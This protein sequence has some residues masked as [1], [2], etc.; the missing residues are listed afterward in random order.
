MGSIHKSP[1]YFHFLPLRMA[2]NVLH[3]KQNLSVWLT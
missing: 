2:C 1:I 3:S